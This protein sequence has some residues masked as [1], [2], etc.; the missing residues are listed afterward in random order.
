MALTDTF[1]RNYKPQGT[2]KKQADGDGLF[3]LLKA[4]GGKW[5]RFS[6]RY[7]GKQKTLSMGVYPDIGLKDARERREAAK[8]L[9]AQGIDP[10]EQRKTAKAASQERAANNFRA[11][12]R[13]WFDVWSNGISP[14][15]AARAWANLE[16]NVF[17]LLGDTPVADIAAKTIL[18]VLRQME[19]RGV[20]NT[21]EK[22]STYIS[23][24]M[25]YAVQKGYAERDPVPDLRGALKKTTVKHFAAIT[26]PLEVGKLL[27]DIDGYQGLPEVVGA[28]RLAPLVFVRIGELREARWSDIDF[29]RAE[30]RY[31]ASKTGTAHSVPLSRQAVAILES[32]R[33]ISG[34]DKTGLVFPGRMQGKP[35]SDATINRALQRMGYDTGAQMTGHGFRAM[36][37]T[38]LAEELEFPPEWIEHQL[39]HSVPDALGTAYNRTKYLKQRREMMQS[40][41]DYLDRLK[42]GAD[43]IPLRA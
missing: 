40:W 8:K 27:R 25:R 32:M 30:W 4:N 5:W 2:D 35:L 12:G 28:L 18:P 11:L 19:A 24:I 14:G 15:T 16:R 13:E 6:Y 29:D 7:G 39:A 31:T 41:A 37:R 42:T 38:L 9:L 20:S 23:R 43:V 21:V 33:P 26:A 34:E 1:L 10:G 22:A 36:A 3:V 17:P